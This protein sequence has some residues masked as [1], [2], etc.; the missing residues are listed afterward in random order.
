MHN[1]LRFNLNGNTWTIQV[2][3]RSSHAVV[4]MLTMSG[5]RDPRVDE[6]IGS[7]Q[8]YLVLDG[9]I[10]ALLAAKTHVNVVIYDPNVTVRSEAG[11]TSRVG[12]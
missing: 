7:L 2:A 9:N 6:Y 4:R 3:R 10:W 1:H 12:S 8:P 11:G 5:R